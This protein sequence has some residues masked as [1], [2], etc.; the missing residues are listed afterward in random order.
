MSATN[1]DLEFF[2]EVI[3]EPTTV[4]TLE[5]AAFI[6]EETPDAGSPDS[7]KTGLVLFSPIK[8]A[9]YGCHS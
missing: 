2:S 8:L 6:L 1:S 7:T 4:E 9:C 3:Q 5:E